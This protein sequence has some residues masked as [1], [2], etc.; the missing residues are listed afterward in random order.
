MEPVLVNGM[1]SP[2]EDGKGNNVNKVLESQT[3]VL[4]DSATVLTWPFPNEALSDRE[5]DGLSQ[6]EN[7]EAAYTSVGRGPEGWIK[8]F[9]RNSGENIYSL[10]T[11]EPNENDPEAL[12]ESLGGA[13]TTHDVA[14]MA[15]NDVLEDA[16]PGGVDIIYAR[17][18]AMEPMYNEEFNNFHAYLEGSTE[19]ER[20]E[21]SIEEDMRQ[22]RQMAENDRAILNS[23]GVVVADLHD[24]GDGLHGNHGIEQ[25]KNSGEISTAESRKRHQ[26]VVANAYNEVF[27]EVTPVVVSEEETDEEAYLQGRRMLVAQK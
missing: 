15:R 5:F 4:E 19:E 24:Y 26:R 16:V 11:M 2:F 7:V 10:D 22:F 25:Q 1:I 27:D 6:H 8:D 3:D 23:S 14:S 13:V 12:Q 20:R 18:I 9:E 17:D 21:L